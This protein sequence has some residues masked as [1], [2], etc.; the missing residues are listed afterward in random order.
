[1][2]GIGTY[3]FLA[4]SYDPEVGLWMSCDPAEQFWNS[5]SYCSGNPI[6][7]IDPDG[8][9]TYYNSDQSLNCVMAIQNPN[10]PSSFIYNGEGGWNNYFASSSGLT[11]GAANEYYRTGGGQPLYVDVGSLDLSN[12]SKLSPS[13]QVNFAGKNFS[14]VNDA[15][16]YG[17]V[18]LF[19]GPNNTVEG[20][21]DNYNFDLK[22][23]STKTFV[24]NFET[25]FGH[26]YAG[27]GTPYRI[28]FIGT[29]PLGGKR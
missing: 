17:T 22:P 5:F 8:E 25:I 9:E 18:T 14:S 21:F 15:L 29:A 12:V 28:E 2:V 6:N 23:W 24:R 16:V 26:I 19:N 27:E 20:G 4:R 13:G 10:D 11:L 1:M 7:G 3:S